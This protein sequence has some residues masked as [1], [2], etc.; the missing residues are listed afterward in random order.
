MSET[1]SR[2]W[3]ATDDPRFDSAKRRIKY[4]KDIR[5]T[6][7]SIMPPSVAT[8]S[9]GVYNFKDNN[10]V[11]FNMG[12]GANSQTYLKNRVLSIRVR[13]Y[14][15]DVATGLVET[16]LDQYSGITWDVAGAFFTG[17]LIKLNNKKVVE[18]Y[19]STDDYSTSHMW[20]MLHK[21]GSDGLERN[22]M[23]FLPPCMDTVD[24]TTALSTN[25]QLRITNSFTRVTKDGFIQFDFTFG[26]LL[27]CCDADKFYNN[28]DDVELTLTLRKNTLVGVH[29]TAS[30]ATRYPVFDI[31]D[32]WVTMCEEEMKGTQGDV[33]SAEQKAGV[34][35]NMEFIQ[36]VVDSQELNSNKIYMGRHKNTQF[37][38]TCF[39]AD[40]VA[41]TNVRRDQFLLNGTTKY[42]A[43]YG[44]DFMPTSEIDSQYSHTSLHREYVR[45]TKR[46]GNPVIAP[47]I[48]NYDF[49][50]YALMTTALNDSNLPIL[51]STD[52][53][54]RA[55]ITAT[56]GKNYTIMA[57]NLVTATISVDKNVALNN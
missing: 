39:R 32:M 36:T 34:D 31:M 35:E 15:L 47:A 24:T 30:E 54:V 11:T 37:V 21:Y 46:M 12:R 26:D 55:F 28:I 23:G 48:S 7:T 53:D 17:I 22:G 6:D 2:Y 51:T 14:D 9:N 43:Q 10:R 3:E 56:T 27:A 33:S 44:S 52:R 8:V 45:S 5:R 18:E 50:T 25:T 57:H 49:L 1:D 20:R 4:N 29:A 42:Q 38:T 41:T 13:G 40:D 16:T 19:K